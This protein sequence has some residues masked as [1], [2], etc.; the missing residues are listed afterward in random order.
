M[1]RS[2]RAALNDIPA[3]RDKAY[4]KALHVGKEVYHRARR[5]EQPKTVLFI[6]GCQRSG[7]TLINEIFERDLNTKVYAEMSRLSSGDAPKRL[8]LN[9]IEEVKRTLERDR[10]PLLVLKPLVESQN[11]LRLIGH[12]DDARVVWM[13]RNYRDVAASYVQ[14]WGPGHSTR[15]L[16]AIIERSP[17]NWRSE[18]VS[19][20]VEQFVRAHFAEDMDSYDASALYWFARN[21]LFFEL[22]LEREPRVMICKYEALVHEPVAVMRGMYDFI[23]REF[24]GARI[25]SAVHTAAANKGKSVTLAAPIEQRCADLLGRL[26]RVW[27]EQG[28]ATRGAGAIAAP[29]AHR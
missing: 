6:V 21:S 22:Q 16:R 1:L 9:P 26:D 15:D 25:A 3:M 24:P 23:G 29:E 18:S 11:I 5:R 17:Q 10:A 13:Y 28:R 12:F 20:E 2:L 27:Q 8:R 14:K 7:T 19:A 4:F